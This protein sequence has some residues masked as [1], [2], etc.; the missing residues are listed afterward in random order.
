MGVKIQEIFTEYY[1]EFEATH[2]L[3]Y[4]VRKAAHKIIAC[5]TASLGGHVQECPEGH[6]QRVWYNSCKHRACNQCSGIQ[7]ENW[8]DKQTA[9]LLSTDHYHVIFTIP[10]QLNE[11]WLLNVEV[12]TSLFFS[13]VQKTLLGIL[14]SKRFY[15]VEPGMIA[16][17]QT[18]GETLFLHPHI[19][20]LVTGG[21][22]TEEGTWKSKEGYLVH[23]ETLKEVFRGKFLD[24]LH[25]LAYQGKLKIMSGV[26][27]YQVHQLLRK[28]RKKNWNVHICERYSH[29]QGVI[30][31]L[32]RYIRGGPISNKRL[33]SCKDNKV[34]FFYDDNQDKNERNIPQRKVMELANEEFIQRFLL[35]IP[36]PGTKVVR[37]YGLYASTKSQELEKCREL[38]GQAPLE[39]VEN[40][41]WQDYCEKQ[42]KEHPEVCPL[43]GAR[44]MNGGT[45]LP[46]R[47][48][49]KKKIAA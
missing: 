47:Q 6:Y 23:V 4:Y 45:I 35:H 40:L 2:P 31:Y 14:R 42:R 49:K 38:L 27:F 21:G 5:R 32:A 15:G 1:S 48:I 12:M 9:R 10:H 29:G 3:P 41:K 18:W 13:S 28:L 33:I 30:T 39:E 34:R 7:V 17:L 46:E 26:E 11:L 36:K 16:T 44:L 20:C 22:L 25:N 19:H 43:C 8:L 24:G 37:F